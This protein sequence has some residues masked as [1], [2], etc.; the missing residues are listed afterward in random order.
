MA[1]KNNKSI[2]S[3]ADTG[4]SAELQSILSV[5]ADCGADYDRVIQTADLASLYTL[6]RTAI[7]F[8]LHANNI[9]AVVLEDCEER[10][11][12]SIRYLTGHPDNALLI[13]TADGKSI[14]VPWDENLAA[15]QAHVDKIIP[16]TRYGR[17]N[18]KAV[19]TILRT[20]N[21]SD[22]PSIDLPPSTPYPLFLRY[23]DA[24]DGWD[25]HCREKSVHE[26]IYGLRAVKD[27]YEIACTRKACAITSHLT[28]MIE[29][30]VRSGSIKKESDVAL[31]IEKE[32]RANGC[33]R[34]GFD[35][36]AA[37]PSRSFAIH[38]FPQYT[39]G[40]WGTKGLS[41]LDYGVVFNGYTSDATITIARGPLSAAQNALLDLVEK[42][43]TEARP[44]Y[45]AGKPLLAAQ[46]KADDIFGKA[47]RTMPHSLGHGIGLEIHEYPYVSKRAEPDELFKPGMIVTLEPG[48]Y[49]EKLG[50]VR[51]ENDVLICDNENVL[52]TNSRIIRL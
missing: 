20:V 47:K 11:D 46:S 1:T 30:K 15:Q 4:V 41:I 42:A 51:L 31:L 52:L 14:L 18:V 26:F 39:A 21:V 12:P 34:T 40:E 19:S 29:K 37:G 48:L 8:F 5:T 22:K 27:P 35:T 50:G 38:A 24:L 7:S 2:I 16:Y 6:R 28:D 23:L 32:L 13:L 10:R 43:A 49:D 33:E 44:L 45:A 9:S 25:V 3:P 17:D 36:L